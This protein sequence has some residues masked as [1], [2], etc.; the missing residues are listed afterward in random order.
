VSSQGKGAFNAPDL[1]VDLEISTAQCPISIEIRARV[2]NAGSLGVAAGVKVRFYLGTNAS[3]TLLGEK[4]TTKAL[5]PGETE[6]VSLSQPAASSAASFFVTVDGAGAS[7]I[8]ECLEDNN[9]A[10]AGSIACP[11]VK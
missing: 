11:G 1:R 5:L 2:K 6:I 7:L 9:S 4:A 10:G 3:G 8:N